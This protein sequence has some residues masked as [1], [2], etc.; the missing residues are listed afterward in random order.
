MFVH[1]CSERVWFL[2]ERIKAKLPERRRV[3]GTKDTNLDRTVR[4][5]LSWW[6]RAQ[7]PESHA[8]GCCCSLASTQERRRTRASRMR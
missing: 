5:A 7:P 4:R 8:V 1:R 3:V 2:D 6:R